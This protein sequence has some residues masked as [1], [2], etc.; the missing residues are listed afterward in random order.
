[1]VLADSS[2]WIEAVRRDGSLEHKVG[3][4]GLLDAAG[5][6]FRGPIKLEVLGGARAE[7]RK[8]MY[9]HVYDSYGSGE[10]AYARTTGAEYT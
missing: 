6:M 5:A 9:Q 7:E 2:V 1:M 10:S 8:R 3:L 4:E